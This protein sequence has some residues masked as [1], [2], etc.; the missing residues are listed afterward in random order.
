MH[1][2]AAENVANVLD[3]KLCIMF[4]KS[5]Y[6]RGGSIPTM[7]DFDLEH[8]LITEYGEYSRVVQLVFAPDS[9]CASA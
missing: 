4:V 9:F 5:G 8:G 3:S 2:I 6:T 7:S 1:E